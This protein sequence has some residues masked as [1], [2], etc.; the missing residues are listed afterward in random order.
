MIQRVG[1][2]VLHEACRQAAEWRHRFP[3]NE[4]LAVSVNI[5]AKQLA[6]GNIVSDVRNALERFGLPPDALQLEVTET[7]VIEDTEFT[8]QVLR[9]LA[10][11]GVKLHMDDFGTGYTSFSYLHKL[12]LHALKLD[13]TFMKS[14]SERRDYAAIVHAVVTLAHNLGVKVV[15]EGVETQEQV[16]MLLAIECDFAQGYFYGKPTDAAGAERLLAAA[17]PAAA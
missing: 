2:W 10:S 6:N 12:P 13:R 8:T 9:E 11:L 16:A 14:V 1:L 3:G 5:S 4:H 17:A 7:A 15:D